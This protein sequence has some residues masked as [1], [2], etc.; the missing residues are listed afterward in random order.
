MISWK[1][2]W[3][4]MGYVFTCK[5][6]QLYIYGYIYMIIY[7]YMGFIW[8]LYEIHMGFMDIMD[9]HKEPFVV[10]QSSMHYV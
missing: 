1:F 4:A 2:K 3:N 7:G 8:D 9:K 6:Q 5:K 10:I